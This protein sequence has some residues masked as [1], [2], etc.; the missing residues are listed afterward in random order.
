LRAVRLG[1]EFRIAVKDLEGFVNA[2][3]TQPATTDADTGSK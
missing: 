1:R 2:H 3:M